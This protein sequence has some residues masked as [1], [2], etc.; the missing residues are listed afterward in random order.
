MRFTKVIKLSNN[1]V[2]LEKY[3]RMVQGKEE[4]LPTMRPCILIK[5]VIDEIAYPHE[6]FFKT[7]DHRDRAF[8]DFNRKEAVGFLKWAFD[9]KKKIEEK[10]I[11]Q[12]ENKDQKLKIL[13]NEA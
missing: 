3:M 13:K 12:I 4:E 6:K 1:E 7:K 11:E 8:Y 10:G 9:L 2:L 5:T